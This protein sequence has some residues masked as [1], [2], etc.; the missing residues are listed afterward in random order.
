VRNYPR[1]SIYDFGQQLLESG[2]LDPVYIGLDKAELEPD[3]LARWLIAYWCLY[4]V[5]AA[6]W[7]SELSGRDFW[8]G[9]MNAAAN[10]A[11]APTSG[12]WPRGSER[13]HFRGAAATKA[14]SLLERQFGDRPEQIVSYLVD[15]IDPGGDGLPFAEVAARARGLPLFGPWIS[16]KIADMLDRLGL[17]EI[18]FDQASVFMFADPVKAALIFWRQKMGLPET[19]KPRDQTLVINEVVAHL[20]EHFKAHTAPPLHDR[21]VGLQEIETILCKWK[22]HLNGHY[23]LFNDINEIQHGLLEWTPHSTTAKALAHS[24]PQSPGDPA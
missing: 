12:R 8:A 20:T 15:G 9:L 16:F 10:D 23:P 4:H 3:H 14:A 5:G 17:A 19:A 18:D 1:L 2:D 22:S 6:S 11:P 7:L 24:M 21:P 13:R